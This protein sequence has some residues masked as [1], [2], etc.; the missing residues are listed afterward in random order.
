M[1]HRV[2]YE[3][4]QDGKVIMVTPTSVPCLIVKGLKIPQIQGGVKRDVAGRG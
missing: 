3:A 2:T 4:R 1:K